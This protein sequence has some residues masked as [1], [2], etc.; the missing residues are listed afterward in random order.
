MHCPE[1]LSDILA[2]PLSALLYESDFDLEEGT[3][4]REI[5]VKYLSQGYTAQAPSAW[6]EI[7]YLSITGLARNHMRH[8]VASSRDN[9]QSSLLGIVFFLCLSSTLCA[10][11][12]NMHR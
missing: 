4:A 1:L 5:S 7:S 8:I 2:L 11:A 3:T 12:L 9:L 10:F 6:R